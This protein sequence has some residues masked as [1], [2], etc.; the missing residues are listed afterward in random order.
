M[1]IIFVKLQKSGKYFLRDFPD[2]RSLKNR[3]MLKSR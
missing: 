2:E 1:Y 3:Y